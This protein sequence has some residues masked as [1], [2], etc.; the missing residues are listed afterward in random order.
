MQVELNSP[1]YEVTASI[2]GKTKNKDGKG[3]NEMGAKGGEGK[4]GT[5]L[6]QY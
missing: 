4:K 1:Y 2:S 3:E 5:T 6:A